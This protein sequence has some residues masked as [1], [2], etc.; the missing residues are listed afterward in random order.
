MRV[1]RMGMKNKDKSEYVIWLHCYIHTRIHKTKKSLMSTYKS[2]M[3]WEIWSSKL[4]APDIKQN[5]LTK[6]SVC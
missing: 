6:V 2:A 1:S 3:N 4:S 5:K